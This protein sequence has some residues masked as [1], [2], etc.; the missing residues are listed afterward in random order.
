MRLVVC[1]IF[2][3]GLTAVALCEINLRSYAADPAAIPIRDDD[4]V[5]P[6]FS[7]WDGIH[8]DPGFCRDW[9]SACGW[10]KWHERGHFFQ[11][12]RL[13]GSRRGEDD[14]DQY[15]AR[16]A[17]VEEM[18]G[19]IAWLRWMH[20]NGQV[21]QGSHAP[22]PQRIAAIEAALRER[23]RDG[24]AVE[25]PVLANGCGPSDYKGIL[26]PG[27]TLLQCGSVTVAKPS[28]RKRRKS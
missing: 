26:P 16:H 19:A 22:I 23:L 7:Q 1:V 3:V 20:R 9:P 17:S 12:P 13:D 25:R 24:L 5:Y 4:S 14:A 10:V 15:A 21:E 6:A 27:A 18:Q 11:S 28:P 2:L 8:V